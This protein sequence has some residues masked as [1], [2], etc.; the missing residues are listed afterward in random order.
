MAEDPTVKRTNPR[1][2]NPAA[3]ATLSLA[4]LWLTPCFGVERAVAPGELVPSLETATPGDVLRLLPG[5][6]PGPIVVRVAVHLAG[7][8]GS[9]GELLS[10]IDGG[11]HGSTLRIVASDVVV[12]DLVVR[13]SGDDLSKDDAAV[14]IDGKADR[15][16]GRAVDSRG[17]ARI[18]E[19]GRTGAGNPEKVDRKQETVTNVTVLGSRI[20]SRAF[21]IYLKAG[22]G[23]RVEGNLV[24]GEAD[25][26]PA[27]RGNGIHLWYSANNEILDNRVQWVRDGIYLSFAHDNVIRGNQ[28]SDLRYGIHYMFSERNR[29]LGNRFDHGTGG[30]A[31]MFSFD[32][33]IEGNQV[34]GNDRF[35]ILCQQLERS[36]FLNNVARGNGRGFYLENSA[37]NRF[38]G[39]AMEGN[40]VGAYLTAGSEQNVFAGNRF[41]R[42]LVQVYRDHAGDNQW[43]REGRGN[44][45]SDYAGFDWDGDGV[46]DIPY[47]LETTASALLARRPEARWF[48]MSPVLSLLDW[49]DARWMTPGVTAAG[50]AFD[51]FPLAADPGLAEP[52]QPEAGYRR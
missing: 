33:R 21:G 2:E 13:R 39:N 24:V 11:G 34:T 36:E 50:R 22:E 5:V 3:A 18:S 44:W 35:G 27:R 10:V 43:W 51:A 6:H 31:L 47:R 32:N 30:I 38:A 19:T 40:G 17:E 8:R 1:V 29:L 49:W 46:G 16:V 28:G 4:L 23:H 37:G 12:S 7:T 52:D 42:N 15:P 20:E 48:W 14:L 45:W 25:R 9:S 41:R 26:P